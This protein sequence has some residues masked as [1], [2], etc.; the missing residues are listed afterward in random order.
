MMVRGATPSIAPARR[1]SSW[2]SP[3]TASAHACRTAAGSGPKTSGKVP[4]SRRARKSRA[5]ARIS[6]LRTVATS[7]WQPPGKRQAPFSPRVTT[8]SA[9]R[10]LPSLHSS[11]S[12]GASNTSSSGWAPTHST[13]PGGIAASASP[14]GAARSPGGSATAEATSASDAAT[15]RMEELRSFVTLSTLRAGSLDR[16]DLTRCPATPAGRCASAPVHRLHRLRHRRRMAV[17]AELEDEVRRDT[18]TALIAGAAVAREPGLIRLLLAVVVGVVDARDRRQPPL[19]VLV[20]VG[21]GVSRPAQADV[22]VAARVR[23]VAGAQAGIGSPLLETLAERLGPARHFGEAVVEPARRH[24]PAGRLWWQA[25]AFGQAEHAAWEAAGQRVALDPGA[26]GGRAGAACR[27]ALIEL[28]VCAVVA[29]AGRGIRRQARGRDQGVT[30]RAVAPVADRGRR[31]PQIG[32]VAIT[33]GGDAAHLQRVADL[34]P[35]CRQARPHPRCVRRIEE[36]RAGELCQT[37]PLA[38]AGCPLLG[39]QTGAAPAADQLR[40]AHLGPELVQGTGGIAHRQLVTVQASPGG[41]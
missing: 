20:P 4:C 33:S 13:V 16:P 39:Q 10:C 7:G 12:S 25:Q 36:G 9:Q 5:A 17:R 1:S 40:T 6:A 32:L 22:V 31:D 3:P 27:V 14:P 24:Q 11:P 28:L 15:R 34:A 23:D 37:I 19:I 18:D 41:E 38:V 8:I 21:E 2:S 29:V 30:M 35:P 26:L